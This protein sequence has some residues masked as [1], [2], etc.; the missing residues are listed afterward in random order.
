MQET[1]RSA[2]FTI[3]E[4]LIAIVILVLG[5]SGIIALF[6]TAIASG[7]QTVQDTYAAQITQSVMDAI[8]VGVRESRYRVADTGSPVRVWTYFILD[9]DGVT[10]P[11]VPAPQSYSTDPTISMA[12]WCIL[13][14]M[15][16]DP[17]N[18]S[19]N[20]PAF[21]YPSCP[22][23]GADMDGTGSLSAIPGPPDNHQ[24]G[25]LANLINPSVSD[26]TRLD[27]FYKLDFN[28]N[29]PSSVKRLWIR[30]V[31]KLG[32]YRATTG[33]ADPRVSQALPIGFLPRS[34][35]NEFLGDYEGPPTTGPVDATKRPQLDPYPQYSFAFSMKRAKVDNMTTGPPP[36]T[37]PDGKI[38]D[39]D[40]YTSGLYEVH[41]YVFRNFDS[42]SDTQGK[43]ASEVIPIPRANCWIK[44]FTTLMS[45]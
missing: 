6:P 38:D 1:R 44:E 7:A 45:L 22:P 29:S 9:H 35:R 14:P 11:M 21:V 25:N 32:R 2:G 37:G 40:N 8:S 4:I 43:I 5:I 26:D 23:R 31:F 34:V 27:S 30:R 13:L 15:G 10:D 36:G 28:A 12:D 33:G 42:T 19:A 16:K 24:Q 3:L 17:N 39:N 41:I 20:E 18:L